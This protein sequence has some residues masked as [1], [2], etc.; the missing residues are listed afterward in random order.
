MQEITASSPHRARNR[1]MTVAALMTTVI[2]GA[3]IVVVSANPVAAALP[4][5]PSNPNWQ[6]LVPGPSSDD[7]RPV[8]VVR[9][10]MA[11]RQARQRS[12]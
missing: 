4:T 2:I 6:S 3:A 5:W 12:A 1:P 8:G 11:Q 9:Q 10:G 7:V